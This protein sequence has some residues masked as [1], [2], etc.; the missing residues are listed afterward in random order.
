MLLTKQFKKNCQKASPRGLRRQI[1][2]LDKQA[3]G[4]E[5]TALARPGSG[6]AFTEAEQTKMQKID[7]RRKH[8]ASVLQKKLKAD[9]SDESEK[10][11]NGEADLSTDPNLSSEIGNVRDK[12]RDDP[13]LGFK[14]PREFMTKVMLAGRGQALSPQLK[15]LNEASRKAQP[16][17]MEMAAGA[18]EHSTFDDARG[19]FLIPT[20]FSPDVL[21]VDHEGGDYTSQTR[22]NNKL[23][24]MTTRVPLNANRVTFNALVDKDH[25]TSVASGIEVSRRAES[26]SRDPSRMEFE[27]VEMT[28]NTL[29]GTSYATE[30]LLTDSPRSFAAL[31]AQAFSTAF[32]GKGINERLFGTGVGEP[33]GVLDGNNPSLLMINRTTSNT[34]KGLD[35]LNMMARCWGYGDAVWLCNHAS[36]V[37]MEQLHIESP[38]NAGILKMMTDTVNLENGEV[39]ATLKGRPLIYTEYMPLITAAKCLALCNFTQYLEGVYQTMDRAESIHVRFNNHERCYKYWLR[40]DGRPWWKS[41]LTPKNGSTMAPFV[42]LNDN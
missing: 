13:A 33:L 38:N 35:I 27:Q 8:A 6:G 21:S 28:C 2:R 37:E 7:A 26:T 41:V 3:S 19:G 24:A 5:A 18:D 39:V 4:V 30:E 20:A 12:W 11:M 34:L 15:Y 40:N 1:A 42:S 9:R 29:W 22:M 32:S 25:S 23:A 14:T 31:I 16:T 17:D 36:L 10:F